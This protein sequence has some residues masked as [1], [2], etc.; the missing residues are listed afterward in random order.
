MVGGAGYSMPGVECR[1]VAGVSVDGPLE[2]SLA[3]SYVS[4]GPLD[5]I[6]R[7]YDR[8]D[9]QGVSLPAGEL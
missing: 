8:K 9:L 6:L 7:G 2:L 1:S 4:L 3:L 5:N